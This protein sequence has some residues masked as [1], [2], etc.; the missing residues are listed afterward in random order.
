MAAGPRVMAIGDSITYGLSYD[1]GTSTYFDAPGG[2][3]SSF[4]TEMTAK[5][6]SYKAVGPSTANPST[7][8]TAAGQ[9]AH[10]GYGGWTVGADVYSGMDNFNYHAAEWIQNYN[11]DVVLLMGGVNDLL[12]SAGVSKTTGN[13][14]LLLGKLY[15][16]KPNMKVL[17]SNILPTTGSRAGS[18]TNVIAYNSAIQNTLVP[19][20]QAMG[21]DIHFVDQYSN[22]TSGGVPVGTNLPD[23]LHPS[24]AGYDLM[25]HTYAN[26]VATYAPKAPPRA[27][28]VV[29]DIAGSNTWN[30]KGTTATGDMRYNGTWTGSL[31]DMVAK[32][33]NCTDYK[34]QW[35][36]YSPVY[37]NSLTAGLLTGDAANLFGETTANSFWGAPSGN[38][39][40]FKFS[41]LDPSLKYELVFYGGHAGGSDVTRFTLSGVT[42]TIG[43]LRTGGNLGNVLT[44]TDILPS[45]A[46]E[47]TVGVT[48]AP[49]SDSFFLNAV[50]IDEVAVPEPAS[51]G[52]LAIGG[53]A[54]LRRRRA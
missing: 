52:L 31:S 2:Y 3:R 35:T 16:A 34:F 27:T 50:Q 41:G 22:F 25:G 24:Q 36:S 1:P 32:D 30:A 47:I 39:L 26:A 19:K 28:P 37:M 6:L 43:D 45:L 53:M 46:G 48:A 13:M 38:S 14:D 44:L 12:L 29:V 10:A 42:T 18:N 20:Y 9:T 7:V 33:G 11:P 40:N 17:V 54:M 23:G 5:G 8:L 4:F 15:A 21:M 51:M 49:G